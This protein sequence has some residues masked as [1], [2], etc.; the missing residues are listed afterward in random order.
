MRELGDGPTP[1]REEGEIA[2]ADIATD[3]E[4]SGPKTVFV[5][6]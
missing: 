5:S 6:S 1:G 3:Q 2:V 4:T